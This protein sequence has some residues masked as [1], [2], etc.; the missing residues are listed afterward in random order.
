MK[1]G[2][3]N[4]LVIIECS[5][6]LFLG[7]LS[8]QKVTYTDRKRYSYEASKAVDG[9]YIPPTVYA[10]LAVIDYSTNPW[11]RVDLGQVHCIWAMRLL[12]RPGVYNVYLC[13][14]HN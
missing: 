3:Q 13:K 1:L 4:N 6:F 12:N 11:W 9:V 7:N 5:R 2:I 10:S 8:K 14:S